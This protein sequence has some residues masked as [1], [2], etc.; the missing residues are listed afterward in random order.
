MLAV[1][2]FEVAVA[3]AHRQAVVFAERRHLDHVDRQ[4][5]V[6]DHRPHHRELLVVL[7]AERHRVGLHQIEQLQHHPADPREMPRPM[8]SLQAIAHPRHVQR[9]ARQTRR[10]HLLDLGRKHHVRPRRLALRRVDIER[11]WVAI[12]I[13][14]RA[15]L[16]GV[17]EN[18]HDHMLRDPTGQTEVREM[19]R[20]QRPHGR[21]QRHPA[22]QLTPDRPQLINRGADF[23]GPKV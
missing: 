6:F 5:Q 2:A 4:H 20:L 7:A 1:V 21:H 8:R 12:K 18:A 11:A 14:V 10:V 22:A 13:F 16:G 17:D 3:A 15:E 23:H 19:P 9:H